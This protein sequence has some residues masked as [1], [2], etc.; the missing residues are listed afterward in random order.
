MSHVN[1]KNAECWSCHKK[2]HFEQDCPMSNSKEQ[3]SVSIVGQWSLSQQIGLRLWL[4]F[5]YD[6]LKRLFQQKSVMFLKKN[7]ISMGTL[8]KQGYKYMS[9][10]GTMKV[11][12]GYLVM[13]KAKMEDGLYTLAGSTIIGSVNAST[14]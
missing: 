9:E 7:L 11:T 5:A 12:K 3:A 4:Y 14:V 13:L 6:I 10:G 8:E 2:G 1:K